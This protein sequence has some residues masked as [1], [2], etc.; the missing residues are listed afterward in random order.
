MCSL[1]PA[2]RVVGSTSPLRR[3]SAFWWLRR[4]AAASGNS[5]DVWKVPVL[6]LR[7]R[8]AFGILGRI[9]IIK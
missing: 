1:M 7:L 5:V 6:L 2:D 9:V 4:L 8:L 3:A